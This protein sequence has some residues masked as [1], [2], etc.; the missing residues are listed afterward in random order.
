M[1]KVIIS[2]TPSIRNLIFRKSKSARTME[3]IAF[4]VG[5]FI[6]LG[7]E[8]GYTTR[9]K[10]LVFVL[11]FLII[12]VRPFIY[13]S[14]VKPEYT[15][16]EKELIIKKQGKQEIF[17]LGIIEKEFDLPFVYRIGDKKQELMISDD[18]ITAL[19][20]QLEKIKRLRKQK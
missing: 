16:T 17:P 8:G 18:F 9:F 6:L 10:I 14:I 12:V 11:A 15:L 20:E 7:I 19:N 4:F 5:L 3:V 2:E 13:R 1:D